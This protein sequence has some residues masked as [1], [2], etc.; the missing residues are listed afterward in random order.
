MLT[1]LDMANI[2]STATGQD[3]CEHMITV[4]KKFKLNPAKLCGLTTDGC[5][6]GCGWSTRYG[7]KH[8]QVMKNVFQCVNYVRARGLNHRQYL[9]CDYPDVVYF[10]AVSWLS[11]AATFKRFWNLR[12]EFKLFME[13]KHHNVAFLSDEN[14]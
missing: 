7:C 12:Q 11:R 6:S 8:L 14:G 3:I 1:F 2:S 13:S 5:L 10:S 9:D 4:V